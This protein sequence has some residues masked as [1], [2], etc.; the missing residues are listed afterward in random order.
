MGPDRLPARQRSLLAVPATNHR[1]LEKAAQSAADAV[2]IDLE[3]AVVPEL[4]FEAR[5]RAIAAINALDWGRR[6][7]AVRVNALDTEWG[8]RDVIGLAE[9][10]PRLDRILLPKCESPS[11]VHAVEAMLGK[12]AARIDALVETA[13]GVA[14]VEAI[15]ASGGRLSAIVF[16]SGDYSLDLGV[17]RK[18]LSNAPWSYVM[19]RIGNACHAYGLTA[20]D[21]PFSDIRDLAGLRADALRAA[22]FGFEGKMAI[23]PSQIDIANEVFSP[24]HEEVVWAREV[25]AAMAA[26][27]AEGQGAVRDKTGAMIDLVHIKIARKILERAERI[28]GAQ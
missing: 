25:L 6:L 2:F 9:G 22:A 28:A 20:I 1:F 24:T 19:A 15:A 4:K 21:G 16:G 8:C 18:T 17:V 27:G 14:N 23:H 12:S 3:D 11:D 7:V 5:A 13:M 10:C 26:A